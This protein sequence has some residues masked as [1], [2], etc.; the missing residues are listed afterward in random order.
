MLAKVQDGMPNHDDYND[1]L[2]ASPAVTGMKWI[3][4]V[5]ESKS[6]RVIGYIGLDDDP[7]HRPMKDVSCMLCCVWGHH[8]DEPYYNYL[9][10][11][12]IGQSHAEYRRV[13]VVQ[14]IVEAAWFE[15]ISH[16]KILCT[17]AW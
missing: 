17:E 11:E 10:L 15:E 6:G 16:H 3:R 12:K 9:A 5:L 14:A 7:E 2:L 13:G 8:S 4:S 1:L